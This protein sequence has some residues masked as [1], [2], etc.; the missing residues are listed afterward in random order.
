MSLYTEHSEH[1]GSSHLSQEQNNDQISLCTATV[2]QVIN[3]SFVNYQKEQRRE[4]RHTQ[5]T[6][7]YTS[8][9]NKNHTSVVM[10]CLCVPL[11]C[12]CKIQL[13]QIN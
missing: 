13:K 7:Y 11:N 10:Y 12:F 6:V 4:H 9:H 2:V 1:S 8:Y 3:T 5:L